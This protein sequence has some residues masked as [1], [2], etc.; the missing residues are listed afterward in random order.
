MISALRSKVLSAA[1]AEGYSFLKINIT[2][3]KVKEAALG[4]FGLIA[5]SQVSSAA[6]GLVS[7]VVC[8]LS[9]SLATTLH[10]FIDPLFSPC[11]LVCKLLEMPPI[12]DFL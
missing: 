7:F 4:T 9:C 3:N 1:S 12:H 6:A 8:V 2:A 11:V 10:P 5:A